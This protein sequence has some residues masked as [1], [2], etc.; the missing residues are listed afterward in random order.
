M[1][2]RNVTRVNFAE[3]FRG[4]ID[5]YNSGGSQNDDFYEKIL[6]FMDELRAEEERHIKEELTEEELELFD[7]LRKDKLTKA[8]EK[9]VR[10]A[11]KELYNTLIIKKEKL[12]IIGWQNDPQPRAKV[13]AEIIECLN[14]TLPD[15]YDPEIFEQKS[16]T[17][18]EHIIDQANMG[19]AWVA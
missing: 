1:L 11:A 12:F 10:V 13:K 19:Y 14:G 4:I 3:R 17:V 6:K 15:S 7:L 16:N 9:R 8:E 2:K 18:F 5:S